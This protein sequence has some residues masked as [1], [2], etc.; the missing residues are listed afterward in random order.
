MTAAG[1]DMAESL[2]DIPRVLGGVAELAA[3]D[4]RREAVVADGDLLVDPGIGE[5]VR[6]LGHGADKDAD[7]LI[8]SKRV[9]VVTDAH[10][11][12]VKAERDLAAVGRQ[13]IGDGV[14]DHLEELFLCVGALD[15]KA[16][17]ELHHQAGET[18]ERARDADRGRDLNKHTL[19]GLDVYLEFPGL[20]DGRVEEGEETLVDV[21]WYVSWQSPCLAAGIG[22][23]KPDA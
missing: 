7:A 9:D 14:L 17:Q 8:G 11:R 23:R 1:A 15:G 21:K 2:D 3:G 20:V 13:V 10:Q 4:A 19:G 16:M 5:V 22:T 12:R 18:L 6:S